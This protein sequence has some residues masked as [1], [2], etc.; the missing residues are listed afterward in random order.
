MDINSRYSAEQLAHFKVIE[1]T[2]AEMN[3]R[4]AQSG[5]VTDILPF[6]EE[7]LAEY[8]RYCQLLLRERALSEE[9]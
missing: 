7:E 4:A 3:E 1:Q 8:S 6:S 5:E 9:D 2:L